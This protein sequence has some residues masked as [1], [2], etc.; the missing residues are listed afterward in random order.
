[1]PVRRRRQSDGGAACATVTLAGDACRRP[2][3]DVSRSSS[4]N[5]RQ[6]ARNMALADATRPTSPADPSRQP[7]GSSAVVRRHRGRTRAQG[8]ATRPLQSGR[9]PRRHDRAGADEGARARRAQCPRHVAVAMEADRRCLVRAVVRS[10]RRHGAGVGIWRAI[11]CDSCRRRRAAGP[12]IAPVSG[13][14]RRHCPVAP[15]L[16]LGARISRGLFR[17]RWTPSS[18]RRLR[19]RDWQSAVGHGPGRRRLLRESHARA[20]GRGGRDPLHP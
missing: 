5:R 2:A 12:G 4:S 14:G 17:R 1:M 6:P 7:R 19:R 11:G 15:S 9:A 10:G 18:C 20:C 13:G 16:S 3:S 8:G